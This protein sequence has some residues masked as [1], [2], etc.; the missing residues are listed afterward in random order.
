MKP[1]RKLLTSLIDKL[2]I[3]T[4]EYLEAV[5]I[6]EDIAIHLNRNEKLKGHEPQLFI[7]GSFKM[8]T[9]TKPTAKDHRYDIDLVCELSADTKHTISKD[10]LKALVGEAL[11]THK[12]YGSSFMP[13]PRCW[14]ININGKFKLDIV[15]AIPDLENSKGAILIQDRSEHNWQPTNPKGYYQWFNEKRK[16][17]FLTVKNNTL[18]SVNL[19]NLEEHQKTPMQKAIQILKRLRDIQFENDPKLKPSS[20][21]ITTIVAQHYNGERNVYEV[22]DNVVSQLTKYKNAENI[23]IE[24]GEENFAEKLNDKVFRSAFISWIQN[25]QDMWIKFRNVQNLDD[26]KEFSNLGFGHEISDTIF[27]EN[28]FDLPKKFSVADAPQIRIST[29]DAPKPWR[30]Y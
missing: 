18:D 30:N 19:E 8:G 12:I 13:K 27:N 2:D 14:T 21:I 3:S 20:I 1:Q 26:L 25:V 10:D 17:Y 16:K 22:L 7:Q 15:P 23:S 11:K 29:Q 28:D 24:E 6:A 9:V 5:N 4:E